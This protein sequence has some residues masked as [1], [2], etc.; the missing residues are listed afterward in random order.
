MKRPPLTIAPAPTLLLVGFLGAGKTT[1]LRA[2]LPQLAEQDLQPFVIINDYQDARVDAERL[3][4]LTDEVAAISGNCVCCD[5]VHELIETLLA[6]PAHP[7]RVILI[8]ANGTTDPQPLIEHL[9]LLPALRERVGALALLGV[10]DVKRWQRRDWHDELERAQIEFASH[11][12][13]TRG[14]SE[15]AVRVAQVR[16]DL[17]WLN[18]RARETNAVKLAAELRRLAEDG[19]S[20]PPVVSREGRHRTHTLAHSFV[21]VQIELPAQVVGL[22][23]VAWLQGLPASVLRVKGVAALHEM[24][25]RFFSF[26]RADDATHRPSLHPLS[27]EPVVPPCAVLIGV[28]LDA[29]ALRREAAAMLALPASASRDFDED[30]HQVTAR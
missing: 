19:A 1:F 4:E 8:E 22:A 24:P 6:I 14:E 23:L 12:L 9:T 30:F 29:A 17:E 5:S 26:Q 28:R 20:L 16:S 10:V 2:I 18:T 27:A 7:R 25:G 3:R 15:G 11:L 21:A 13:L